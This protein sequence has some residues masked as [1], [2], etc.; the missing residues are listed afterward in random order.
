M[1]QLTKPRILTLI[2]S[3][4]LALPPGL[5]LAKQ[6]SDAG[7]ANAPAITIT[8]VETTLIPLSIV[9]LGTLKANQSVDIAAQISGRVSE[10]N[11]EDGMPVKKGTQLVALDNREQ[12]AKVTEAR[13]SLADA[14]RQLKY[15]N[16]L[17]HSFAQSC[18]QR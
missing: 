1:L 11:I 10:L 8:E 16:T 12:T 17:Y 2:A 6:Q 4:A 9:S 7:K 3:I 15:I 14:K 18:F 5:A 13:I